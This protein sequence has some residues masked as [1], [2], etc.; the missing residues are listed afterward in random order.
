[1]F[2]ECE[3]ISKVEENGLRAG[4]WEILLPAAGLSWRC[5]HVSGEPRARSRDDHDQPI[6]VTEPQPRQS[7]AFN[8]LNLGLRGLII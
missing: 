5:I 4:G 6:I 3:G 1:M 8:A 2:V 7:E